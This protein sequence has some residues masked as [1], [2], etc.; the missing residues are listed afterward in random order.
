M[1]WRWRL[2][3]AKW[4]RPLTRT[5]WFPRQAEALE[6]YQVCRRSL[7]DLG[8]D[9]GQALRD[10]EQRILSQDQYLAFPT[11]GPGNLTPATI[12]RSAQNLTP[13]RLLVD[14]VARELTKRGSHR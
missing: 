10:L 8:L 12:L 1:R 7:N 13:A 3:A 6:A 9:P 2:V 11:K 14:G 5:D 4:A